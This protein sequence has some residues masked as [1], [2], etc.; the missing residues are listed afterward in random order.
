MWVFLGDGKGRFENIT[1]GMNPAIAKIEE[2]KPGDMNPFMGTED[3]AIG[4]IDGDGF[5][6]IVAS[7]SDRGGLT[8]YL[9]NGSGKGWKETEDTGLPDARASGGG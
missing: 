4:D 2:H 8:V 6:D 5:I 3:L 7:A 9:G 1:K